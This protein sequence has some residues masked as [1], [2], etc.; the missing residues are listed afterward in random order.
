MSPR[1]NPIQ[2][3]SIE[4]AGAFKGAMQC[5]VKAP[6]DLPKYG[7]LLMDPW[8]GDV[9]GSDLTVSSGG[10]QHRTGHGRAER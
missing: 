2:T 4:A 5:S 1:A 6:Y 10:F 8:P 3:T 7:R 9:A